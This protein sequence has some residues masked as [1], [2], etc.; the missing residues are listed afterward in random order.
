MV[1]NI[2]QKRDT[3]SKKGMVVV[4]FIPGLGV[5]KEDQKEKPSHKK[6]GTSPFHKPN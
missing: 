3:L 2:T 4:H 5:T 6:E 1:Q